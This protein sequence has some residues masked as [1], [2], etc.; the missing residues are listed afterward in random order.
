MAQAS[1]TDFRMTCQSQVG[2]LDSLMY[3]EFLRSKNFSVGE[4]L[5]QFGGVL[6]E[7]YTSLLQ[8]GKWD[9]LS[10][11][12]SAFR[13]MVPSG[14]DN[15]ASQGKHKYKSFPEWFDAQTCGRKGCG[16]RH[17]TAYHDDLEAR[18]RPRPSKPSGNNR[19]GPRER[20]SQFQGNS[21]S[22]Q[23]QNRRAPKWKSKADERNFQKK[24]YQASLEHLDDDDKE[25]FAHLAGDSADEDE[26]FASAVEGDEEEDDSEVVANVASS[27]DAL[28]NW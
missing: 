15:K 11:K 7:R 26:G 28:L 6:V 18:D 17:P 19:G 9:G 4:E 13:A 20:K 10:H 3:R 22:Q 5:D 1:N 12:V 24:V 14:S 16:G 2:F 21:T 25:L 27:L 8:A 23:R